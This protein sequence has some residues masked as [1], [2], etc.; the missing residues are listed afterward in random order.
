LTQAIAASTLIF[1][2]ALTGATWRRSK[3]ALIL[4]PAASIGFVTFAVLQSPLD[5]TYARWI[6]VGAVLGA[7]GDLALLGSGKH[8]FLGGL[9]AFAIGHLAYVA[10]FTLA[11]S[12][13]VIPGAAIALVFA[14]VSLR[15]L[16]PRVEHSMRAPVVFYAAVIGL[17]L[18]TS[19]AS[20]N[21]PAATGAALF[22]ISDLGVAGDRL[23][24]SRG[25]AFLWA[26]PTY[27]M[28][29]LLI[30]SSIGV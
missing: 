25:K 27:Y 3:L 6:V 13:S 20:A 10:A 28:A 29:Q 7:V 21:V 1:A 8:W 17:M 23:I 9:F 18:A 5:P 14:A 30:A 22:A 19:I 16:L 2:G 15:W 12:G 11:I 24:E 4:K 26:L